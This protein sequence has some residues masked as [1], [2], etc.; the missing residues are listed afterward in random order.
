M[1]LA[2]LKLQHT[3]M[4]MHAV[5]QGGIHAVRL[6][7]GKLKTKAKDVSLLQVEIFSQVPEF[8]LI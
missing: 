5:H 2:C 6:G 1:A 7:K 3:E 8:F 4:N